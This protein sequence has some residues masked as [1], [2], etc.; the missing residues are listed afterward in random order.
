MLRAPT[1]S[2]CLSP[3]RKPAEKSNRKCDG[4][5]R[6]NCL[7]S[8]SL[9]LPTCAWVNTKSHGIFRRKNEWRKSRLA[10]KNLSTTN[11][12]QQLLTPVKIRLETTARVVPQYR[13]LETTF[14]ETTF[15]GWLMFF[16]FLTRKNYC[17]FGTLSVWGFTHARHFWRCDAHVH[18]SRIKYHFLHRTIRAGVAFCSQ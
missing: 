6:M 11:S 5:G 4:F 15:F 7:E 1:C 8:F 9:L 3:S 13:P 12:L 14:G 17:C 10:G 16:R 2:I 18:D